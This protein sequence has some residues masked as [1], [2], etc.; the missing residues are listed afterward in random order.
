MKKIILIFTAMILFLANCSLLV[1][2]GDGPDE[3]EEEFLS[4]IKIEVSNV[5]KECIVGDD[6]LSTN[7]DIKVVDVNTSLRHGD[8]V[9][10]GNTLTEIVKMTYS[11]DF[12]ANYGLKYTGDW[13]NAYCGR[14]SNNDHIYRV[15]AHFAIFNGDNLIEV[16]QIRVLDYLN[17]PPSSQ[18]GTYFDVDAFKSFDFILVDDDLLN[19]LV[20]KSRPSNGNNKYTYHKARQYSYQFL[21]FSRP[22]KLDGS[23]DSTIFEYSISATFE[24]ENTSSYD[25]VNPFTIYVNG[26]NGSDDIT[27]TYSDG[28]SS[29][30]KKNMIFQYG[31]VVT[32]LNSVFSL[33]KIQFG[34]SPQDSQFTAMFDYTITNNN[35]KDV[36][37]LSVFFK[38]TGRDDDNNTYDYNETIQLNM[39]AKS[40]TKSRATL[41]T[42]YFEPDLNSISYEKYV[43]IADTFD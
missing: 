23:E 21:Y 14:N 22:K 7:V 6:I 37:G 16:K 26:V 33:D 2:D 15:D 18:I 1:L 42:S 3:L 5:E 27:F 30:V 36:N 43:G 24:L 8:Y 12:N 28:L 35:D 29:G 38:I 4:N 32:P 19:F 9:I 10:L 31:P 25:I 41:T 17:N 11:N 13:T 34:T 39:T 20:E 40:T